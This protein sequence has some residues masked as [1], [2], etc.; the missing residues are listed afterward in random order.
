MTTYETRLAPAPSSTAASHRRIVHVPRRFA[1]D[2]WGGT[3]TV[4]LKLCHQQRKAGYDPVVM[5]SNA[6]NTQNKECYDDVPVR[7][8]SYCY[9]YLRLSDKKKHLLDQKGGNLLSFSL[10][11]ALATEGDVR[12]FHAHS[13]MRLG[14]MVRTA[15]KMQKK[16]FV[17]SLHGGAFDGLTKGRK[18]KGNPNEG[19]FDW[20]RLFDWFLRA[21]H[22]LNHADMV[23]CMSDQERQIALRN[24]N[25][26]RIVTLPHGVD[27]ARFTK[28]D[29]ESFREYHRIPPD[30]FM[31]LNVGRIEAQKNQMLLLEAFVQLRRHVPDAHLVFIGPLAQP[32]Y[33]ALMAGYITT[34]H[35]RGCVRIL[36]GLAPDDPML[37]N[38]Y[39]ATDVFAL[40]SSHEPS[41]TVMLEA[42]CAGRSV[43]VN[44]VGCLGS[45]VSE[46]ETGLFIDTEQSNPARQLATKLALLAADEVLRDKLGNAGREEAIA[47]YDWSRIHLLLEQVYRKAEENA[48]RRYGRVKETHPLPAQGEAYAAGAT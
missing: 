14:G 27:A 4:V 47:K 40:P 13:L 8:F 43:V 30:A 9:P 17:V 42:W 29:G 45:M 3:E 15:A 31:V 20:G 39:N 35:L 21:R 46:N 10:F 16:P 41:G 26:D 48:A 38:A 24:L 36:P 6:L 19:S 32:D 44:K 33:A 11:Y 12:L 28:G 7:R 34:H 1:A 37:E 25:H 23:I 2:H 5:T 18:A 22:V